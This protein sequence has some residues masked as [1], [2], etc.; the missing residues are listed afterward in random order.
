M[1]ECVIEYRATTRWNEHE[2]DCMATAAAI[3]RTIIR[4]FC[5]PGSLISIFISNYVMYAVIMSNLYP[6]EDI[7]IQ[8]WDHHCQAQN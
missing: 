5:L 3:Y 2:S 8:D 7:K 4:N 1:D 6:Y